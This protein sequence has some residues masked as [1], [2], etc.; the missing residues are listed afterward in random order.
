MTSVHSV[1]ARH[2]LPDRLA[3]GD[4]LLLD[5]AMG[6]DLDRRGLT[7]RLP[8]WSALGVLERPDL[9]REVHADN[10]RA[11]ADVITTCTF[12]TT[13]RTLVR[14]G[15][16]PARASEL[17]ALA[18]RLADDARR[19]TGREDALVAGSIA[20]LEDCYSPDLTPDDAT[21]YA[22]HRR[23]A[24]SLAAAG[25]DFLMIETMPTIR[26]AV[27]ALR[28]ADET[29]IPATVGF[30]CA[31]PDPDGPVLLLSGEPLR[32]AVAAVVPFA[33]AAVLVNCAPAP[34]IAAAMAELRD[35]TAI[36]YGG[37]ANAGR[38]DDVRGWEP[39]PAMT[40][41]DYAAAVAPW[42]D[43]GARIVGGCCGSHAG[44]T[45]G[46]RALLDARHAGS[47]QPS[48]SGRR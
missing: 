22:E 40:G 13:G 11:G 16:D 14:G 30:V 37:Y 1:P 9:V 25:V 36:P 8:L 29:G 4:V 39:D 35:A 38:I 3:A 41:D 28:A 27:A 19:E 10:L 21:A 44:H 7:T 43:L 42:L 17:D 31:R 26:E 47:A 48:R 2:S 12:R 34:V 32:D 20:P 33:P 24:A 15:I 46:V 18:A 23:Q 6:T 5:A 45:A